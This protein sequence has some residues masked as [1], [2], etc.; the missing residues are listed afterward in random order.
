MMMLSFFLFKNILFWKWENKG[1]DQL[2][3]DHAA[4]QCF[5]F[6]IPLLPKSKGSAMLSG[7]VSDSGAR[8]QEF[9]T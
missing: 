7:R 4:Y 3:C 8:G 1:T 9:K 2:H 6:Y 5:F